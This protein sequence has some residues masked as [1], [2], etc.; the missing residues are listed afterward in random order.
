MI[1]LCPYMV[2]WG[3][4]SLTSAHVAEED[5]GIEKGVNGVTDTNPHLS[6]APPTSRAHS[7]AV[8]QTLNRELRMILK[9]SVT[10]YHVT[11]NLNCPINPVL[12]CTGNS[13]CHFTKLR[14]NVTGV[15]CYIRPTIKPFLTKRRIVASVLYKI[16]ICKAPFFVI[17][18]ME[19]STVKIEFDI[20]HSRK[21]T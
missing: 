8:L 5:Q 12:S 13:D 10:T 11:R 7:H 3:T 18:I 14:D 16:Q 4:N 20:S 1:Y 6:C 19:H 15:I 9:E 2:V 17:L 21:I